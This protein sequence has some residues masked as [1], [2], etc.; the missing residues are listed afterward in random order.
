MLLCGFAYAYARDAFAWRDLTRE[1]APEP[2]CKVFWSW[3]GLDAA[4]EASL[5]DCWRRPVG[6]RVDRDRREQ[7]RPTRAGRP[8]STVLFGSADGP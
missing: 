3:G 6:P 2:A 7:Q 1:C 5:A 4:T 8:G